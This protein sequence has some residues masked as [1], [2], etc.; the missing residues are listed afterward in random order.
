MDVDFQFR[1]YFP[2]RVNIVMNF[3]SKS[4][5]SVRGFRLTPL[6]YWIIESR[7]NLCSAKNETDDE[8]FDAR[9]YDRSGEN[10]SVIRETW[11]CIVIPTIAFCNRT[12][13]RASRFIRLRDSSPLNDRLAPKYTAKTLANFDRVL[14]GTKA[15]KVSCVNETA[16]S[17]SVC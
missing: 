9:R 5:T 10:C 12:K 2:S 1:L 13:I 8:T 3:L 6:D 16:W 17:R 15:V 11:I 7:G 14:R 4:G